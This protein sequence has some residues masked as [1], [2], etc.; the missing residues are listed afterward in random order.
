VEFERVTRVVDLGAVNGT[1]AIVNVGSG[2]AYRA[3]PLQSG[4]CGAKFASR[5]LTDVM[6]PVGV[7]CRRSARVA[8]PRG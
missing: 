5:G 1:R 6:T 4:Y 7:G 8:Q 3:I 2:L